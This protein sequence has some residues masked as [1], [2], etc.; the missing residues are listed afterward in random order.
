MIISVDATQALPVYEQICEQVVRMVVAETMP[1][2]T[3]MPTI[4]QL[5]SD[6]Q[7]AK[8][9][10]AKAYAQLEGAGVL[11]SFGHRGT[12]VAAT[13]VPPHRAGAADV[14]LHD[15]AD[16]YVLAAHQVGAD[17]DRARAVLGERWARLTPG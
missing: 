5:A 7:L 13:P 3:R 17:L 6:L 8:G 1:P 4:R 10:V 12:F 2:G 15:V 14:A 9:T 16:A 11:E